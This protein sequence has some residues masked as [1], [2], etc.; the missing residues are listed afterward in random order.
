MTSPTQRRT[1]DADTPLP[2]AMS[3]SRWSW[4]STASTITAI[5]PGGCLRH[6]DPIRFR[7]PRSRSATKLIVVLDSG[8]RH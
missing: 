8:R 6:R 5:R 3:A 2:P 4:R 1:V 7:W